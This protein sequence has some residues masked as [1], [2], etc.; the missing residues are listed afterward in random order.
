M[1]PV[2]GNGRRWLARIVDQFLT[3][4]DRGYF[5][6]EG[7]AGLGK[8]TFCAWLARSRGYPV[9]FVQL[10]GGDRVDRALKN[11]AAR[12]IEEYG[13]GEEFAPDGVMAPSRGTPDGF[14]RL[15]AAAG[16]RTRRAGRRLVLVV[17]GLDDLR[18]RPGEMPLGLPGSLP[19]GAYL[20][21]SRRPVDQLLA[22]DSRHASYYTVEASAGPGQPP[23]P[24]QQ[25]MLEYLRGV[26]AEPEMA[27]LISA[28]GLSAGAFVSRLAATC[29]GVWIYLKYV[30]EEMRVG[31]RPV[32]DLTTLPD[33]LWR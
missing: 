2:H 23:P 24:N 11:L 14:A 26:A 8:T 7:A 3:N 25:D 33:T 6:L 16:E 9:H 5:V 21:V 19:P 1:L 30:L 27:E 31:H 28:A 18:A 32:A 12:L 29:A 13:L 22:I 17:D 20:L 4:R 15:L 10:P